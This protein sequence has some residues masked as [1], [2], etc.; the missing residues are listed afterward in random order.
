MNARKF[1]PLALAAIL[2]TS[3]AGSAALA[4]ERND[5]GRDAAALANAKVSLAQAIATAEQQAGGKAVGAGVDNENG[6]VR[7][8]VEVAD[9]QGVKTVLVDPL[10]GQVTGTHSG[11]DHDEEEHD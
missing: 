4:K 6:T 1:V 5:E 10:S 9:G 11:G 2:A 7:I 8:A 3:A